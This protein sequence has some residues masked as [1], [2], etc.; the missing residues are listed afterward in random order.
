MIEW[1]VFLWR[2]SLSW[3]SC[4]VNTIN[5]FMETAKICIHKVDNF[6]FHKV[7]DINALFLTC[8]MSF[9]GQD[10]LKLKYSNKGAITEVKSS[11]IP[12][13]M[14]I[15]KSSS[16]NEM[17]APSSSQRLHRLNPY[18]ILASLYMLS[19][20][21]VAVM[22]SLTALR[23]LLRPSSSGTRDCSWESPKQNSIR[24]TSRENMAWFC[25]TGKILEDR[26]RLS[27]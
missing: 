21:R 11:A 6:P 10:D 18:R 2:L 7:S 1:M 20:K 4:V 19:I 9:V 23:V 22:K 13:L 16:S 25:M 3:R 8:Y 15:T 12:Q 24:R 27:C 26:S 5:L 17:T 14:E